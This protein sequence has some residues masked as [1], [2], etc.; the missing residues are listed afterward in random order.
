M[1]SDLNRFLDAIWIL[2]KAALLAAVTYVLIWGV[3]WI[4]HKL[5]GTHPG[6]WIMV[7]EQ[8]H[9]SISCGAGLLFFVAD[10]MK[11]FKESQ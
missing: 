5:F 4:A 7:M 9:N 3:T 8:I 2:V 6:F 11:Y 10:L 1:A